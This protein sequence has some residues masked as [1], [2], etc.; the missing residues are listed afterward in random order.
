MI[1]YIILTEF[2][3]KCGSVVRY[4]HPAPVKN[5]DDWFIAN[6]MLPEGSHNRISDSTYFI[7]NR[8]KIAELN[9]DFK[10]TVDKQECLAQISKKFLNP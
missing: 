4:Q 6:Y 1:D 3:L 10:K 9:T 5:V 8:K 7:L 2:D